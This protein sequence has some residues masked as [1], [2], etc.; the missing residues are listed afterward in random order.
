[1]TFGYAGIAFPSK[2]TMRVRFQ[3]KRKGGLTIIFGQDHFDPAWA[4]YA[5]QIAELLAKRRGKSLHGTIEIETDLPLGKG[6][7]SSTALVIAI[8]KAILGKNCKEA[9]LATEDE[10]NPGHS[11]MDFAVIWEGRPILFRR[12]EEPKTIS[13][14]KNITKKIMLI[15][16]G[17]PNEQTPKLVA[18]VRSREKEVQEPLKRI[19]EC[20]E[21]ILKN[22]D[23]KAIIRDHHRAQIALGVVPPHAQKIIEDIESKGGAGKIIGAGSRT[24]GGGMVLAL[25]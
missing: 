19:G 3:S 9:A 6:M 22:E 8:A 15:D 11:G 2:E 21:R 7:G 24:G 16:T 20:T 23:L 4:M 18:W 1:M 25:H 5:G 14:P 10:I 12:G 17:V 13:L